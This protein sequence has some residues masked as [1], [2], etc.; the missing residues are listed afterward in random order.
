MGGK[1]EKYQRAGTHASVNEEQTVKCSAADTCM[2][3]GMQKTGIGGGIILR[4]SS[5]IYYAGAFTHEC[6]HACTCGNMVPGR[7]GSS[8]SS[9]SCMHDLVFA[10]IRVGVPSSSEQ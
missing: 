10:D 2:R 7:W 5:C 6:R 3:M 9:S 4:M 8:S 1:K